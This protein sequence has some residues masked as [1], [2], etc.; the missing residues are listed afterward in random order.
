MATPAC[1]RIWVRVN[2]AVSAAKSASWIRERAALMFSEVVLRFEIVDWNRFWIAPRSARMLST[3]ARAPS[4]MLIAA[5][6]PS[7]LLMSICETELS[8]LAWAEVAAPVNSPPAVAATF[9]WTLKELE[10]DWKVTWPPTTVE[11][12]CEAS[13]V[14]PPSLRVAASP[15]APVTTRVWVTSVLP[16]AVSVTAAECSKF[17]IAMLSPVALVRTMAL[18]EPLISAVIPVEPVLSLI[19]VTSELRSPVVTVA[20]TSVAALL[21]P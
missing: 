11:S 16:P 6:A 14:V 17:S 21:E 10:V 5:C 2:S 1:C 13:A 20:E 19:A 3:W 8:V 18:P 4:T 7:T 12:V 9:D 15:V